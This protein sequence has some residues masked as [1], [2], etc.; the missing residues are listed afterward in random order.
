MAVEK[1]SVEASHIMMFARAIGDKNPIY[2]DEEYAKTTEVG[3]VIAPPTFPR[4]VAQFD[5]D[6]FL[7]WRPSQAR[8]RLTA[9]VD[10]DG[11]AQ[12]GHLVNS[13]IDFGLA[14]RRLSESFLGV[15]LG[16]LQLIREFLYGFLIRL[17]CLGAFYL[18][19]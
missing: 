5:P 2:Y 4:S 8:G 16:L 12:A 6:Y 11:S 1:F 3:H 19:F 9:K 15:L 13:I 10:A 18:F 17:F 14:L 7:R